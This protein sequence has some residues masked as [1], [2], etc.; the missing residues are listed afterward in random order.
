M[1]DKLKLLSSI[2]FLLFSSCS[3]KEYSHT[4]ITCPGKPV[5]LARYTSVEDVKISI[6]KANETKKKAETTENYTIIKSYG[7]LSLVINVSPEDMYKCTLREIP[8][9]HP[10]KNMTKYR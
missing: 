5:M 3:K 10:D 9:I 1:S 6:V 4:E 7:G 8:V 2:L